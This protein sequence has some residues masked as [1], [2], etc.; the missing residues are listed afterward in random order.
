MRKPPPSREVERLV[1]YCHPDKILGTTRLPAIEALDVPALYGVSAERYHQIA[2]SIRREATAAGAALRADE[3]FR[4]LIDGVT[5]GLVAIGDSL[6]DDLAS[7][8]EILRLLVRA[9]V[10]NAGLSGDTT[11]AALARLGRLPPAERAIV[12][13]GTN[14]ARRHGDQ[15]VLVSDRETRRNLRAIGQALYR[16]CR[17]VTWI[18]PP[19][20]D[21]ARVQRD[22]A[23]AVAGVSWRHADIAAK[24]EI[25]R[26]EWPDALDLWP[27]FEAGYLA[28][29]GVHLSAAGQRRVAELV[30][31][32]LGSPRS[33]ARSSRRRSA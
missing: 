27:H 7:W 8:A 13:L 6:T 32:E 11:T 29:D 12:L 23:L 21:E 18:T 20:V 31:R 1:R 25:V 33:A 14:D 3:R 15:D 28:D 10:V 17:R 16:R 4:T 9:P 30:I 2:G 24:A 19:P 26:R 5:E 22:R